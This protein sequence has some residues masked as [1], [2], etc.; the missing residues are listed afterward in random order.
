MSVF[1]GVAIETEGRRGA[2][3]RL[4]EGG[5]YLGAPQNRACGRGGGPRQLHHEADGLLLTQFAVAHHHQPKLSPISVSHF[6]GALQPVNLFRE[7]H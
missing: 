4:R 1:F 2:Q 5:R 6:R 7:T 3:R